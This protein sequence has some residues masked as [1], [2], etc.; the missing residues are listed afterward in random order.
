MESPKLATLKKELNFLEAPE[1]KELCLRLA[2]HKTENKELLHFLLFYGDK[3]DLYVEDVKNILTSGFDDLHP[4]V[5]TA[6]KQIRKVLRLAN[7]HIKFIAT[8]HLEA[9]I[10]S[11]FCEDFI[12]HTIAT[13][14]QKATIGI[15]FNQLKRLQRIIAKLDDDL[16]FDYQGK[17]DEL[18]KLLKQKRP[19][20]S[21][22]ELQ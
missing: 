5:Y 21:E 1:L 6:T 7:K 15:L 22:K 14:H 4:S 11:S 16:Q 3:K 13:T 19:Y 8:K 9:E 18:I 12:K 10:V 20:F 2:K 17:F